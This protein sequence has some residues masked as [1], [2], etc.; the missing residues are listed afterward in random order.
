MIV[1]EILVGVLMPG[2]VSFRPW[3]GNIPNQCQLSQQMQDLG[4]ILDHNSRLML[5]QP[6]VC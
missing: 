1:T 6:S 3:I 4:L 2:A 5:M